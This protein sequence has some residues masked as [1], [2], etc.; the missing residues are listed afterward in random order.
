MQ[1]VQ[2][3]RNACKAH[4]MILITVLVWQEV[5]V[6]SQLTQSRK[7]TRI[8]LLGVHIAEQLF[9]VASDMLKSRM[10]EI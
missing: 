7:A 4:D 1:S 3:R 6:D 8:Y 9:F 5:C 10:F 2:C